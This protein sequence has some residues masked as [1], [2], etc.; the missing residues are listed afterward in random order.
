MKGYLGFGFV[1]ALFLFS[2][3]NNAGKTASTSTDSL[4]NEQSNAAS[5]SVNDSAS[6]N[7]NMAGSTTFKAAMDKMMQQMHAMQMTQ[8][9]DHDFAMMMKQHHQ[10]AIDMSQI[11]LARGTNAELK[12]VAQKIIDDSQ[13]DINELN[14]F[15]SSHKPSQK[16]DFA[17]KQMDKMMQSM[18][19]EHG[20]DIDKEFAMMMSMHHQQGIEMARDY[21][22]VS[23]ADE[24]K[25]V[26]NRTINANS[27]DLKKLSK[28]TGNTSARPDHNMNNM[29][30]KDTGTKAA[31]AGH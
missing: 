22:K 5:M 9:P 17:K 14:A 18:N 24:T 8:D 23:A 30:K 7:M 28:W 6:A 25:N 1:I 27:E 4:N 20:S 12:Q 13:K 21:L 31:H 19:M 11:E 2:C 15:L 3:G 26:A 16:S 10:G 29:N